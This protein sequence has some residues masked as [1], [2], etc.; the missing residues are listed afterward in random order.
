MFPEK[1]SEL[2]IVPNYPGDELTIVDCMVADAKTKFD[3]LT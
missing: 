1:L 2:S 3:R